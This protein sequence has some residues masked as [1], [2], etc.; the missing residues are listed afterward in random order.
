MTTIVR[1][2]RT[3]NEYI[4][5]GINGEINKVN[6]SRFLNDLF[7]QEKSEVACSATV[8]DFRGNIFLVYIDDLIVI[9]IDGKKL[10]DILPEPPLKSVSN[11]VYQQPENDFAEDELEDED[12]DFDD[13]QDLAT[14]SPKSQQDISRPSNQKDFDND[15]NEDEDWI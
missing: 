7:N 9:E 3:G 12:E 15:N 2:K 14:E 10:T 1:H 11:D 5:L 4:L 8:C 6:P 13:D